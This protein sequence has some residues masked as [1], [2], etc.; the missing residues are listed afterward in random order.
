M[1]E[2]SHRLPL[3]R[4]VHVVAAAS[5]LQHHSGCAPVLMIPLGASSPRPPSNAANQPH[6]RS[7][8]A[9]SDARSSEPAAAELARR[10][11]RCMSSTIEIESLKR[12]SA[13]RLHQNPPHSELASSCTPLIAASDAA[14]S[15]AAVSH[16]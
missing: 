13:C 2:L 11:A 14:A 10:A 1:P 7:A 16:P 5:A 6:T 9:R 15:D 3:V 8:S 4:V 12:E